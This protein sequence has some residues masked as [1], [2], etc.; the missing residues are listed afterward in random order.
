MLYVWLDH[1]F[2]VMICIDEV[3][4]VGKP[5]NGENEHNHHKHSNHL[6]LCNT[7]S[8]EGTDR[9][10]LFAFEYKDLS[11]K[12]CEPIHLYLGISGFILV[13]YLDF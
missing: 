7:S 5:A 9:M 1:N 12:G 3:D 4:M 6:E 11:L 10:C 8:L 13:K 2:L